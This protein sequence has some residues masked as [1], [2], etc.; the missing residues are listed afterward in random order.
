VI[1]SVFA[2]RPRHLLSGNIVPANFSTRLLLDATVESTEIG[3]KTVEF[4]LIGGPFA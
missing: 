3:A 4:R 2:Y 1:R